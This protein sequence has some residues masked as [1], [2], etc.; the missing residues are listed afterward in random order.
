MFNMLAA[1][2]TPEIKEY[3]TLQLTYPEI[4]PMGTRVS[5]PQYCQQVLCCCRGRGRLLGCAP[6]NPAY[7]TLLLLRS[8]FALIHSRFVVVSPPAHTWP[9]QFGVREG[10]DMLGC[11]AHNRVV[12]EGGR[13]AT[14]SCNRI[15]LLDRPAYLILWLWGASQSRA[16]SRSY[17]TVFVGSTRRKCREFPLQDL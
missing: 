10:C 3:L 2:C 13:S 1:I 12:W 7:Y 5:P 8:R 6:H 15:T 16:R 9:F 11:V 4:P 17:G 14:K